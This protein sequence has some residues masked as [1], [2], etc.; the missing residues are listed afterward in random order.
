MH[1][2]RELALLSSVL[3]LLSQSVL[4]QEVISQGAP[5]AAPACPEKDDA[6]ALA[7]AIEAK[8]YQT[9]RHLSSE[10]GCWGVWDGSI[11]EIIETDSEL[12]LARVAF[13]SLARL[14]DGTSKTLWLS[15]DVLTQR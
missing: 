2:F 13:S 1:A 12:N 9:I 7:V 6:A 14:P 10:R 5:D 8:D 4:A 15:L 3:C 11:G